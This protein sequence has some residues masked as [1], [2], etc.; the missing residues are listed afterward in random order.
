MLSELSDDLNSIKK[1]QSEWKTTLIEIKYDLQIIYSREGKAENQISDCKYKEEKT[2]KQ[3]NKW[4]KNLRKW[5]QIKESLGQLQAHQSFFFFLTFTK[6][7]FI[8]QI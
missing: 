5:E 8:S 3:N 7:F 1:I 6:L 4:K 2:L